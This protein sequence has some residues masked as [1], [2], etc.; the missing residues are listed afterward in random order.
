MTFFIDSWDSGQAGATW[1]SGLQWDVNIGDSLGDVTPYLDLITSEHRSRPNYI[2][3]MTAILQG[4]CD[5]QVNMS[6]VPALFDIDVAVGDQLDKVGEWIGATREVSVALT[7]VYFSLGS[8]TLGLGQGSM[9]GPNDPTSGLI[10]L[11]DSGYRTL[12][13][14]KIADNHWDGSIPGAYEAW[15]IAFAGTGFSI[16]II[17]HGDM[18]MDYVLFGPVPDALTFALFT[19]GEL[20]L[21]PA[22]VAIDLYITP[23]ADS[24]PY[25]GLGTESATVA[26]LG[27]GYFGIESH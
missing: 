9:Q 1:D 15:D 18:H 24:V 17:D 11:P 4:I 25:F 22:G 13:R 21:R 14:A 3:V 2:A 6:L 5:L 12:L 7:G 16:G 8:A 23:P 10:T 19:G 26:G 27:V 20:S